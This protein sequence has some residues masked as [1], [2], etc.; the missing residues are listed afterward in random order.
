MTF[1]QLYYLLEVEK[2]G[3]FSQAAKNLFITQSTISNA[4]AS[5]EKETGSPIF[6]R[7]KKNLIPTPS[8]EE[9]IAHAKRICESH[10]YITARDKPQKAMVRIGGIGFQPVN[11]AFMR[12]LAENRGRD[13]IQFALYDG[14]NR[15]FT[16]ELLS[17]RMDL[18]VAMFF[19]PYEERTEATFHQK[20]LCYEKLIS[21]P[22][23]IC[24][25]PGHRFYDAPNICLQDL[26]NDNMI[27]L[28]GKPVNR[29][30]VVKAYIPTDPKRTI[31]VCNSSVRNEILRQGLGYTVT[32]MRSA[33]QRATTDLQ[34][35]P[36]EGLSYGV[37]AFYDPLHPLSPETARYLALLKEEIAA[38]VI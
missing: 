20:K 23:S 7:G 12:L 19:S 29:S 1:Q 13:D 25:G 14:R 10:R 32:H 11:T 27:E 21:I 8:G 6:V 38:Y 5:L 33:K 9:I 18:A 16:E 26:K 3:S 37:Y 4:V 34:Y 15:H 36:I 28:P 2:T 30:D 24:I 31:L 22:A 35:I 17:F